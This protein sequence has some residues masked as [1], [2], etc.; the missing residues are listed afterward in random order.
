LIRWKNETAGSED[1]WFAEETVFMHI[2]MDCFFVSVGLRNYPLLRGQPVVVTHAKTDASKLFY[3]SCKIHVLIISSSI[4]TIVTVGI[5]R[6]K[7]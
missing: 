7:I 2:D 3:L 1:V 6:N 4:N 5:V